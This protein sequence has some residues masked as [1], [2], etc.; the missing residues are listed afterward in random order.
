[1]YLCNTLKFIAQI[2]TTVLH[3]HRRQDPSSRSH[4]YTALDYT[5]VMTLVQKDSKYVGQ[6]IFTGGFGYPPFMLF[7]V[8]VT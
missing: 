8:A 7:L 1:M 2:T 3:V 6:Y 5:V 4:V